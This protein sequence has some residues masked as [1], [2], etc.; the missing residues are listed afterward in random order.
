MAKTQVTFSVDPKIRD[1]AE[2]IT[3]RIGLSLSTSINIYL[4]QICYQHKIPF[5]LSAPSKVRA[6]STADLQERINSFAKGNIG[7]KHHLIDP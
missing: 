7:K 5:Q 4:R 3:N 6:D 1:E 2:A